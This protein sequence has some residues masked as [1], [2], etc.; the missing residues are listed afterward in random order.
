MEK[1]EGESLQLQGL[2]TGCH[3]TGGATESVDG[4]PALL[5]RM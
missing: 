5:T 4:N 1:R 2:P 3:L